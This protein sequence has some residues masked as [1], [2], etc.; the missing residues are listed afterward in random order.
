MAS[1][2]KPWYLQIDLYRIMANTSLNTANPLDFKLYPLAHNTLPAT[3]GTNYGT[4]Y[5]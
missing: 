1:I 2:D 3:S 5:F 4:I